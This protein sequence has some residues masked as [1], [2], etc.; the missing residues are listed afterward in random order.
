MFSRSLR[1]QSVSLVLK[2]K[3]LST[4]SSQTAADSCTCPQDAAFQLLEIRH[5]KRESPPIQYFFFFQNKNFSEVKNS[6][7]LQV[8]LFITNESTVQHP[9]KGTGKKEKEGNVLRL[10]FINVF[11]WIYFCSFTLLLLFLPEFSHCK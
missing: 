11:V 10:A 8:H 7:T 6:K 5:D 3:L 2:T 9:R 4:Y 1:K